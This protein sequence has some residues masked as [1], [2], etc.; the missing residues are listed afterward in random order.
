MKKFAIVEK[1]EAYHTIMYEAEN[2]AEA[3]RK[4]ENGEDFETCDYD[5]EINYES[6][7]I[8]LVREM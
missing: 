4:W 7:R 8:H 6:A 5:F 2:E 3:R 1:C